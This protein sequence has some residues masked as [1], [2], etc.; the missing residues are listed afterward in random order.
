MK[1]G[2]QGGE[3]KELKKMKR[4]W[5]EPIEWHKEIELL[6]GEQ[7]KTTRIGSQM[8]P[9]LETLTIEFLK[10]NNDISQVKPIK[11]K[12]RTFGV[13][14]NKIINEEVNKLLEAGYISEIQYTNWL[15][16]V[17]II[18]KALGKWRMCTDFTDL[19]KACPKDP[20]PLTYIDLLMDLTVGCAT[21]Q[22]LVN[23]MF[24]DLIGSMM[25]MYV[26]DMLM[27][28]RREEE[29]LKHLRSCEYTT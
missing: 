14:R 25:E 8:M 28:S 29:H 1:V 24:K 15:S 21:Y 10:K 6:L 19:N 27:K 20:Y 12:K 26:D 18:P 2:E 3:N 11:Q 22:R 13:E 16:S 5:I 17:V 9:E 7:G 23:K 4:E